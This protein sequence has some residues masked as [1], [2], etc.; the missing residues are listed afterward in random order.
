MFLLQEPV[1]FMKGGV[2]GQHLDGF[3][4]YLVKSFVLLIGQ[5]EDFREG[6]FK[7]YC[8]ITLFGKDGILFDFVDG[9]YC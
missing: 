9:E 2:V 5:G 7:R 8:D 1:L 4:Q 3:D 6:S